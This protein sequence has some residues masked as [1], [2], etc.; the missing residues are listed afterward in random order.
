MIPSISSSPIPRWEQQILLAAQTWAAASNINLEVVPD[1]GTPSGGGNNQEGDPGTGD[2]RIGGYNYGPSDSTLA[3][4]FQPPPVNNFSLAGDIEINTGK[5]FNINQTY[6]LFTVAAHELGHSLG[7]GESSVAGSMMY[8]IYTN[9]ITGLASDDLAGI[10]SLYGGSRAFD[11][12]GGLNSTFLTASNLTAWS[13]R[14][15]SPAWPT[16]SIWPRSAR[17]ISQRGRA[18]RDQRRDAGHRCRARAEPALSQGDGL[19]LQH[20]HGGRLGQRAQPVRHDPHREHPQRRRRPAVLHRGAGAD[21]TVFSTGDYSLGLS[22]NGTTPPPTEASPITPIRTATRSAAGAG[23]RRRARRPPVGAPEHPGHQ[24]GHRRSS[25]DGITDVN[26]IMITGVAPAGETITVYN[27]GTLIGTTAADSNGN[28]TF[29]NTGTALPDGNYNFTATAT[30]PVGNVKPSQPFGVTIDTATPAAPTIGGVVGTFAQSG[31]EAVTGDS[32]PMFYG[33]A[34]PF[35]QITLYNGSTALGTAAVDPNGHW[36]ITLSQTLWTFKSAGFTATTADVA[37]NVSG[38]SSR[39]TVTVLPSFLGS[40]TAT[41]LERHRGGDQPLGVNPDGSV[42]TG[43]T[44][45]LGGQA[46]RCSPRWPCSR[47]AW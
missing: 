19:Q 17:G 38:S 46:R 25:S 26:R 35:G 9:K 37:G 29:D 8:P 5:S 28:W 6:D 15:R 22:F 40:L 14:T 36:D 3:W 33:T 42:N 34:E 31:N 32:T 16:T 44:V 20:E 43:T 30:D 1:D 13:A 41:S 21:S 4:S 23:R 12:Y 2:I 24:P 47:T 45:T 18:R 39:Y 10:R 11:V 27:H 7:L